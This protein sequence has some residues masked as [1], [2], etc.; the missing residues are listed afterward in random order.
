MKTYIHSSKIG[1]ILILSALIFV[2]CPHLSGAQTARIADDTEARVLLRT[3][4]EWRQEV[5]I[6]ALTWS[7]ELARSAL[8]WAQTLE[9]KCEFRHSKSGY[10]ENLWKGTSG[11][12]STRSVVDSWAS[13]KEDYNYNRNKCK[14][15]KVC[16][17]YTQIVWKNTTKVGCARL[18]CD[19]MTT[20]VCQYDPP[21]NW[22]GEKPY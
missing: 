4:N 2:L 12:F 22:V 9:K 11:A 3:H 21:G 18:E 13:E 10:G 5:G 15:G 19:G 16:G 14:P 7:D 6:P 1:T 8:Q 17:H 20:W